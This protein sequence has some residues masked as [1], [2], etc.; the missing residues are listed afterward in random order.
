MKKF[1]K[2]SAGLLI[3]AL[4]LGS[5][6]CSNLTENYA[7]KSVSAARTVKNNDCSGNLVVVKEL[8]SSAKDGT[9]C[10]KKW[11]SKGDNVYHIHDYYVSTGS[12][13]ARFKFPITEGRYEVVMYL[14][15]VGLNAGKSFSFDSYA[16]RKDSSKANIYLKAID[17]YDDAGENAVGSLTLSSSTG[18]KNSDGYLIL[19]KSSYYTFTGKNINKESGWLKFTFEAPKAAD[20]GDAIYIDNIKMDYKDP[21]KVMVVSTSSGTSWSQTGKFQFKIDKALSMGDKVSFELKPCVNS[22]TLTVRGVDSNTKWISGTTLSSDWNSVSFTASE[23]DPA[24]GVTVYVTS[25]STSQKVEIKN[26]TLNGTKYENLTASQWC[27]SPAI[28]NSKIEGGS[29]TEN[30][31]VNPPSDPDE[32]PYQSP[33]SGITISDFQMI[34]VGPGEDCS[35]EMSVK[36]HSYLPV[37]YVEYTK[38][39]DTSFKNSKKIWVKAGLTKGTFTGTDGVVYG[40]NSSKKNDGTKF[41]L[42]DTTISDLQADTSYIYRVGVNGPS[43]KVSSVRSFKTAANNGSSFTFFWAGDLHTPNSGSDCINRVSELINYANTNLSNAGKKKIDYVL[44]TGDLVASGGKYSDWKN[45][46]KLPETQKYMFASIVG[47][48][49]Y[50]WYDGYRINDSKARVSPRWQLECTAY[51]KTNKSKNVTLPE[52]NYWYLYNRVLF[53]GIDSLADEN[54]DKD[55][56][57][58]ISKQIQWFEE[59]VQSNAGN[60]DYIVAFQHYAYLVNDSVKYGHYKNWYPVYDTYG[61]DFALAGDSHA[62]S[63]T[64]ELKADKKVSNGGTVYVTSAMTEGSSLSEFPTGDSGNGSGRCEYYGG[65]RTG[66]SYFTVDSSAMTLYTIGKNGT[67]Y[68]TKSVK[69]KSR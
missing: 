15:F 33:V 48:H 6:S 13:Y 53:I 45:W 29:S 67:V 38:K 60:Y 59:V 39:D 18:T 24:I 52:S 62:Y 35:K 14:R 41:Y 58:S 66:A 28:I 50:Y 57:T 23:G 43:P 17:V 55:A 30:P 51:P 54:I 61:V 26:F 64:Y 19:D 11:T 3:S 9:W 4:L 36:W 40:W 46:Y 5:I 10:F 47:N 42:C 2:L 8:T 7:A 63:R 34:N 1:S 65:T 12:D 32:I 25:N 37:N 31:P 69:R 68:D 56:K 22:S 27:E 49:D 20:E 16:Y 21:E 44:F